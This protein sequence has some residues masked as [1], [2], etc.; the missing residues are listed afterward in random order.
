MTSN[1]LALQLFDGYIFPLNI[2]KYDKFKE[3]I[4]YKPTYGDIFVTSY[5]KSGTTW[6]QYIVWEILNDAKEPPFVNEM[7][8]TV[9]AQIELIG[10][11]KMLEIGS[12]PRFSNS[13]GDEF[14]FTNKNLLIIF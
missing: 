9:G 4:D 14:V 13:F 6:T 10:S 5:P 8:Y 11:K 12:Q 2:F 1:K 3:A 7:F